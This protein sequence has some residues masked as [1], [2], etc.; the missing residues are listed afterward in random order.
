ML[1]D[2]ILCKVTSETGAEIKRPIPYVK[3]GDV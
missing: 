3:L 1:L 2:C